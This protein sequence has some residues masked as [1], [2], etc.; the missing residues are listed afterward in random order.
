[1]QR[2]NRTRTAAFL[3]FCLIALTL[4]AGLFASFSAEVRTANASDY[5]P[6]GYPPED[7]WK[8]YPIFLPVIASIGEA[9]GLP[10]EWFPGD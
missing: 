1:M 2:D 9:L 4:F 7:E 5:P 8:G 10:P 3:I 6:Y